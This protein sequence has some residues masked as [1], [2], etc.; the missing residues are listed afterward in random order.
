MNRQREILRIFKD[1]HSLILTKK[2]I[3]ELA[4]ITYYANTDK[5]AGETLAR[6]VNND[7]L[8]RVKRG[9]YKLGSFRRKLFRV[10]EVDNPNQGKLF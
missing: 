8:I 2:E 1:D 4:N 10:G 6:M 7:S 3:L 9:H 5:H